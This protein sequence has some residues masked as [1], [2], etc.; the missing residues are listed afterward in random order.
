MDTNNHGGKQNNVRFIEKNR[1][2]IQEICRK[3]KKYIF[4]MLIRYKRVVICVNLCNFAS[5]FLKI[6]I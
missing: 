3:W 5:L 1:I 4:F 2:I 6:L